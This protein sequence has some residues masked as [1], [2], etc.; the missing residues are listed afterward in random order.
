MA[1]SDSALTL[2]SLLWSSLLGHGLN[3][4]FCSLGSP[5]GQSHIHGFQI[6]SS[7]REGRVYEAEVWSEN[8][9]MGRQGDKQRTRQERSKESCLWWGQEREQQTHLLQEAKICP[10]V[11]QALILFPWTQLGPGTLSSGMSCFI[12]QQLF[13]KPCQLACGWFP[14]LFCHHLRLL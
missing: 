2:P 11:A 1:D 4:T 10:H 14:A 9:M 6:E 3:S 5:A 7:E 13:S 12:T 8:R